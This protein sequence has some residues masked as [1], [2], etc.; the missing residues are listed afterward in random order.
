MLLS[1]LPKIEFKIGE[2]TFYLSDITKNIAVI[3][4][5]LNQ[6]V[7][8]EDYI[9]GDNETLENISFK[10]YDNVNYW[11]VIA[12]INKIYDYR[13]DLPLSRDMWLKQAWF[14]YNLKNKVAFNIYEIERYLE[15]TTHHYELNGVVTHTGE[16]INF[17]TVKIPEKN[18]DSNEEYCPIYNDDVTINTE[19]LGERVSLYQFEYNNNENKRNLKIL[20][21]KYI[22]QIENELR[23]ILNGSK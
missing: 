21:K 4:N 16:T 5:L 15:K 18:I 17:S 22:P 23:G 8:Y 13:T 11:W 7:Y 9:A 10:H 1:N 12:I 20:Q 19:L 14:K 2:D 6:S 3:S